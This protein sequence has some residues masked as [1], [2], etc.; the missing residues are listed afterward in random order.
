MRKLAEH[1]EQTDRELCPVQRV[2]L[3]DVRL[4]HDVREVD[5][6]GGYTRRERFDVV[7]M[8]GRRALVRH[9]S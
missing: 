9:V 2:R 3:R 8:P 1:A 6:L 5:D 7:Q 4:H